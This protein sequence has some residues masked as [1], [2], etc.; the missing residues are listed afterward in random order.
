MLSRRAALTFGTANLVTAVFVVLGVFWGLPA[1]WAPVDAAAVVLALLELASG[2]GLVMHTRWALVASRAA[3]GIALAMGLFLVTVLAVT[4]SW[5][6]GVYAPIGPGGALIF[7]MI[8]V[9]VAPYLVVLPLV[10]LAW[11]RPSRAAE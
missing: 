11:L 6:S 1:R 10:E 5:L 4:A 8:I 9:L 7:L 3:C 2:I